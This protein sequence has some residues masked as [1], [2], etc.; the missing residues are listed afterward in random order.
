MSRLRLPK[1]ATANAVRL[2]FFN[3]LT[4]C[5]FMTANKV[6][7]VS[8]NAIVLNADNEILFVRRS[9]KDDFLP[10]CWELPGGGSE[11]GETPQE[12]LVREIKEECGIMVKVD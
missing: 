8:T 10:G 12:A 4:A 5:S 6:Q 11:Y 9:L 3:E 2:A 1:R 7:E